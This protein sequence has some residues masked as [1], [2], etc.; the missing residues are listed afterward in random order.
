MSISCDAR[1]RTI[2][3]RRPTC[4]LIFTLG[5]SPAKATSSRGSQNSTVVTA[6]TRRV[7]ENSPRKLDMSS[8][9]SAHSESMRTA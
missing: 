7:P 5:F 3:S 2:S 4:S 1:L 9:A 6:P 8:L